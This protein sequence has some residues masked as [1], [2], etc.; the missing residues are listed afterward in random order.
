MGALKRSLDEAQEEL[1]RR[2]EARRKLELVAEHQRNM[3]TECAT[4]KTDIDSLDVHVPQLRE[5]LEELRSESWHLAEEK[6][7]LESRQKRLAEELETNKETERT[8]GL[9]V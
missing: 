5:Q 2:S 7:N 8:L 4:L 3:T 6:K 1:N 9:E